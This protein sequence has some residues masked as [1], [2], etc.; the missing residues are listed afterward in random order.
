MTGKADVMQMILSAIDVVNEQLP[1]ER[2]IPKSPTTRLSGEDAG[3]DS[4]ALVNFIVAVEERV[5]EQ[6]GVEI[7]LADA[8]A[9]LD[10]DNPFH[11]VEALSDYIVKLLEARA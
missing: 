1:L 7:S 5:A 4:L 3:L 11:S 2:R 8:A 6:I 9:E 10:A